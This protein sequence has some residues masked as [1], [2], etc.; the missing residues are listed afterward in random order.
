MTKINKD[1][2][3]FSRNILDNIENIEGVENEKN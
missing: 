1:A 3:K 2:Q